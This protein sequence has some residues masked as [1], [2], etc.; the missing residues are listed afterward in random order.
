MFNV[1]MLYKQTNLIFKHTILFFF[2]HSFDEHYIKMIMNS[3][4]YFYYQFYRDLDI[5]SA[6]LFY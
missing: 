3:I 5:F 1:S 4:S 6:L 2:S